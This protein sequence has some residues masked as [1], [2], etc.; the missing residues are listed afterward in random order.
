MSAATPFFRESGEGEAVICIHAS[1]SSS[2]QWRPLM[3][4]LGERY[5]TIAPDLVGY[6]RSSLAATK[7]GIIQAT[8][9][10]YRAVILAQEGSSWV[11]WPGNVNRGALSPAN[12]TFETPYT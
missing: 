7:E 12:A 10:D 4:R 11:R 2:G 9:E 6:G 3:E 5:R 1:A 8:E